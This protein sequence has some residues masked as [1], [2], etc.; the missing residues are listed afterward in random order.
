MPARSRLISS[1]F[2]PSRF[3]AREPSATQAEAGDEDDT[4][5]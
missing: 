1:P 2:A 3:A 5:D 4:V